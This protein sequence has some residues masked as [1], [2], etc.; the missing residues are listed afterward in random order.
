MG[1][2]ARVNHRAQLDQLFSW[3]QP[4]VLPGR[5]QGLMAGD[6]GPHAYGHPDAFVVIDATDP[7]GVDGEPFGL[8]LG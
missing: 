8:G 5:D 7:E 4:E 6:L 3:K 2:L 1:D